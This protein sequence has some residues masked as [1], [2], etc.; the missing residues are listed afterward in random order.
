MALL[1]IVEGEEGAK[2]ALFAKGEL[3]RWYHRHR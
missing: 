1:D 3:A 2:D